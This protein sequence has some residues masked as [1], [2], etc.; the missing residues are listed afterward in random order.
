MSIFGTVLVVV[1]VVI[2]VYF[3]SKGDKNLQSTAKNTENQKGQQSSK[4]KPVPRGTVGAESPDKKDDQSRTLKTT[5]SIQETEDGVQNNKSETETNT[6]KP[7]NTK[8]TDKKPINVGVEKSTATPLKEVDSIGK[9]TGSVRS[10][11]PENEDEVKVLPPQSAASKK[12]GTERPVKVGEDEK[13]QLT[14][15]SITA[16]ALTAMNN[17]Q[18]NDLIAKSNM[19][20]ASTDAETHTIKSNLAMLS[21]AKKVKEEYASDANAQAWI[22]SGFKMHDNEDFNKFLLS[23]LSLPKDDKKRAIFKDMLEIVSDATWNRAMLLEVN[24]KYEE[25]EDS[26]VETTIAKYLQLKVMTDSESSSLAHQ[27]CMCFMKRLVE[28]AGFLSNCKLSVKHGAAVFEGFQIMKAIADEVIKHKE[29]HEHFLKCM[30]NNP[31]I[32]VILDP[33]DDSPL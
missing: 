16:E 13:P 11:L 33:E 18:L 19:V 26:I 23:H 25:C 28:Q 14:T 21:L 24:G 6:M 7:K 5:E 22:N 29:Q 8:N 1:F 15:G 2:L 31:G 20:T 12:S 4:K 27:C 17:Q 3:R 32:L 10:A 9:V 30:K